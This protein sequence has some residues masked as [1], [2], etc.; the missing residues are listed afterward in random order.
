MISD[1]ETEGQRTKD[2]GDPSGEYNAYRSG[3]DVL[4]AGDKSHTAY[5]QSILPSHIHLVRLSANPK[6]LTVSAAT[7]RYQGHLEKPS[8]VRRPVGK[9]LN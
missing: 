9:S 1:S 5:R 7:V 8:N 6:N 3:N 2:N 4:G